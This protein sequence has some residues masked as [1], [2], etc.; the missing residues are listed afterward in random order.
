MSGQGAAPLEDMERPQFAATA[1]VGANPGNFPAGGRVY[2]SVEWI[3]RSM[4][5]PETA[6]PAFASGLQPATPLAPATGLGFVMLGACLGFAFAGAQGSRAKAA[7][8]R[9]RCGFWIPS[10]R[11]AFWWRYG[12]TASGPA[13]TTLG[14]ARSRARCVRPAIVG[15]GHGLRA[16]AFVGG[17][18]LWGPSPDDCRLLPPGAGFLPAAGRLRLS[19]HPPVPADVH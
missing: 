10:S 11:W 18:G 13:P 17:R 19:F 6:P 3:Q 16:L 15:G 7:K 4:T 8:G 5:A 12:Q 2:E 14:I 9:A 1:D